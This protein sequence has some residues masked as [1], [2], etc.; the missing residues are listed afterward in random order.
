M[1]CELAPIFFCIRAIQTARFQIFGRALEILH[2]ND[3]AKMLSCA[4]W[5]LSHLVAWLQVFPEKKPEAREL[6][7]QEIKLFALSC[8]LTEIANFFRNYLQENE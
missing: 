1:R 5:L 7:N 4:L 8:F 6:K 3:L 2:G